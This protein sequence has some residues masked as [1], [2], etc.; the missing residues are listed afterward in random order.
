MT[1]LDKYRKLEGIGLWSAR[2]EDQRREV[3]VSFGDATLVMSDS[4]SMQV[5]RIGPCRPCAGA[6]PARARRFTAPKATGPKFWNWMM[7]G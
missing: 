3:V 2:V 5:C 1:A 6:T 4:R 7:T